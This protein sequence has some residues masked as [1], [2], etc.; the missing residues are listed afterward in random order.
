[1]TNKTK[2]L[3]KAICSSLL[4]FSSSQ[5]LAEININGFAS[6]RANYVDIESGFNPLPQVSANEQLTFKDE[7]LFALQATADLS[8]G[9]TATIQMV[10]EGKNDF[11]IEARWAYLSYELDN[12]HTINVGKLVNPIFNQSQYQQVGYAHN[13]DRLPTAVY[14]DFEFATIEGMS[15]NSNFEVG[16]YTLMTALTYGN[17]QGEIRT[18][19]F[20]MQPSEFTD[21]M[22]VNIALAGDWWKVF[23]GGFTADHNQESLDAEYAESNGSAR[24]AAAD[25][26]GASEAEL[27][28]YD[29]LFTFSGNKMQYLFTGFNVDYNNFLVDAEYVTYE[30]KDTIDAANT[31]WYVALG[32]RFGNSTITVYHDDY[33]QD[34]VD[35]TSAGL[36]SIPLVLTAQ[37]ATE[38]EATR[39]FDGNGIVWRYDFHPRAALKVGAYSGSSI[40]ASGLAAEDFTAYSIGVD[41]VF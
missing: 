28:I 10:A 37:F 29:E 12:Q 16:D 9:L 22:S 30:T 19:N 5:A 2:Y 21:I 34:A 18:D 17:W 32:Y 14:D 8:E 23:A 6:I 15:L 11:N 26:F 20:G 25:A 39:Q 41:T 36:T 38:Q 27:A 40:P 3:T 13:F 7:S 1:M 4:I 31:S 24:S 33:S 35:P